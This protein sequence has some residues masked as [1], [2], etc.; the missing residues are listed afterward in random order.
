MASSTM[1]FLWLGY[2]NQL[3][4]AGSALWGLCISCLWCAFGWNLGC[5]LHFQKE[6]SFGFWGGSK[7]RSESWFYCWLGF[8]SSNAS[9]SALRLV[10][11]GSSCA[12]ARRSYLG[13]GAE[14]PDGILEGLVA[15]LQIL[16]GDMFNF[17]N[18]PYVWQNVGV[19]LAGRRRTFGK[20]AAYFCQN[21]GFLLA[22]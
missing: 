2:L 17:S 20:T 11:R 13:H 1:L 16:F 10:L 3:R 19:F 21:A 22:K 15:L 5:A 9:C 18:A 14:D 4:G 12:G 7:T 8:G 6:L